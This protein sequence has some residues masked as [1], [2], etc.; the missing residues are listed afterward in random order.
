MKK[1]IRGL[2]ILEVALSVAI[3]GLVIIFIIGMYS[4]FFTSG[5]KLN[6]ENIANFLGQAYI[7]LYSVY[8]NSEDENRRRQVRDLVIR[9]TSQNYR[10]QF[11]IYSS[12]FVGRKNYTIQITGRS[13][14]QGDVADTILVRVGVYW[15]NERTGNRRGS[16]IRGYGR[17]GIVLSKTLNVPK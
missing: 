9:S 6:D 8:A 17:T 13:L 5:T 16:I 14:Y 15:F 4:T 1:I 12:R 10:A 11:G 7:N 3:I 2:S